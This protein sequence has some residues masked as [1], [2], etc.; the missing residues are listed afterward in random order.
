ME[1][2]QEA[3]SELQDT[4]EEEEEEETNMEDMV[5]YDTEIQEC[6]ERVEN[7]R[8]E[9]LQKKETLRAAVEECD[10]KLDEVTTKMEDLEVITK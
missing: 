5:S 6:K 8:Q 4:E 2:L 1:H 9:E 3:L 7:L 10:R